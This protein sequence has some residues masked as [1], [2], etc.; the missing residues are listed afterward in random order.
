MQKVTSTKEIDFPELGWGIDANEEKELPESKEA[1]EIILARPEISKAS[2]KKS[3]QVE[4][5]IKNK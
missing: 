5:K 1:Q 2:D 3:P 4:D